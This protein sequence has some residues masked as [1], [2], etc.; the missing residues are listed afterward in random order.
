MWAHIVT[1]L[2]MQMVVILLQAVGVKS[3]YLVDT[4]SHIGHRGPIRLQIGQGR[5]TACWIL[6][7][8]LLHAEPKHN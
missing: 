2:R 5:H 8:I 7:F 1:G 3:M 4:I 6:V